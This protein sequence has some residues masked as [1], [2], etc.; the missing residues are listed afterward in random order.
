LEVLI[1]KI[2]KY[3][4]ILM[5]NNLILNNSNN[6]KWK[7]KIIEDY[8][9]I[10]AATASSGTMSSIGISRSTTSGTSTAATIASGISNDDENVTPNEQSNATDEPETSLL[11]IISSVI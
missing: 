8:N 7:R 9:G 11:S 4:I 10:T 5:N 1:G 3:N 6:I 2:K